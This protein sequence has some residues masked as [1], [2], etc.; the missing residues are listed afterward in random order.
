M[1]GD[2]SDL[3]LSKELKEKLEQICKIAEERA[4]KEGLPCV[5]KNDIYRMILNLGAEQWLVQKSKKEST[6][7]SK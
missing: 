4:K 1:G 6:N 2:I 7:G 3:R 5:V